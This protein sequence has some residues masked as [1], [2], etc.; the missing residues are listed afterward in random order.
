ME[1]RGWERSEREGWEPTALRRVHVPYCKGERLAIARFRACSEERSALL[2][3]EVPDREHRDTKTDM[4]A[5]DEEPC[6]GIGQKV[7]GSFTSKS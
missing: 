7:R 1:H 2:V 5:E 6:V 4:D 3:D